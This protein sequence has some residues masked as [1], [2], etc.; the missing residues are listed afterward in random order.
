MKG[1]TKYVGFIKIYVYSHRH[2][3]NHFIEIKYL[4]LLCT[5]SLLQVVKRLDQV[6]EELV[7]ALLPLVAGVEGRA[8]VAAVD[9][10]QL[11]EHHPA[12]VQA[13]EN[14]LLLPVGAIDLDEAL[15]VG[16]QVLAGGRGGGVHDS[17]SRL[18]DD[19]PTHGELR[20]FSGSRLLGS[21][22][23][24]GQ[25]LLL[26]LLPSPSLLLL[27]LLATRQVQNRQAAVETAA[28]AAAIS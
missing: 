12:V 6:G 24:D 20:F 8:D 2:Q 10:Q 18:P 4:D 19:S 22:G 16:H 9:R 11:V 1:Q 21:D 26:L 28:A 17:W 3:T 13:V 23:D 14:L 25:L 15:Q 27:L 7:E 5:S